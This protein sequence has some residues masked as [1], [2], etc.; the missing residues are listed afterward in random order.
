MAE[1]QESKALRSHASFRSRSIKGQERNKQRNTF[2][3]RNIHRH[4][5]K[6][7]VKLGL[8]E[9]RFHDLRHSYASIL[10]SQ[11]V[12]PKTVQETLGHSTITLTFDTYSHI[13]PI[14]KDAAEKLNSLLLIHRNLRKHLPAPVAQWTE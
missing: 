13:L 8:P 12:H 14:Q 7:L 10:A 2:F 11:N 6:T 1:K 3:H 9:I 5:K 4:F